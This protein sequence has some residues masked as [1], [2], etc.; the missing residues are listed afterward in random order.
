MSWPD[1]MAVVTALGLTKAQAMEAMGQPEP[2]WDTAFNLLKQGML[3]PTSGLDIDYYAKMFNTSNPAVTSI[4][5][6]AKTKSAE[7]ATKKTAIPKK[8]G[9]KGDKIK[10][11]FSQ[12]PSNPVPAEQFAAQHN[13]SVAVLRQSKRFY[14]E[15]AGSIKVKNVAVGGDKNNKTL[16]IWRESK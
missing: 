8:R 16:M 9:R 12:I 1:R 15:A 10:K 7:T 13:V 11:A 2:E 5:R 14:P 6:P 4:T 3:V